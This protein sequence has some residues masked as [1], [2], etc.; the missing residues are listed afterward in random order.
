MHLLQ[1]WQVLIAK[2]SFSI[3]LVEMG[4]GGVGGYP[5]R[6]KVDLTSSYFSRVCFIISNEGK[7]STIYHFR[8][9]EINF[10][11]FILRLCNN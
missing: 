3:Y 8:I 1:Y 4:G 11:N 9:F 6:D 2:A 7:K 5:K 10:K